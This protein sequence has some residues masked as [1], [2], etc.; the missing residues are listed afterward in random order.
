MLLAPKV[1]PHSRHICWIDLSCPLRHLWGFLGLKW[2]RVVV[3][4]PF[5]VFLPSQGFLE[6]FV[7]WGFVGVLLNRC[8]RWCG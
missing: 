3:P 4:L 7:G 8:A 1:Y 5:V 6:H 2:G